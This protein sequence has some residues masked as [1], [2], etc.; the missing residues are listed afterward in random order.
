MKFKEINEAYAVLSDPDKKSRY[1]QFGHAGVDPNGMG[2]AGFG[3]FGGFGGFDFGDIFS[4]FFGGGG[5]SGSRNGPVRGESIEQRIAISFE[6][7]AFGCK[8]TVKYN[9][10][11]KCP[12]CSGSGAAKGTRA[13]TC[14]DCHGSGQVRVSQRTAFGVFQTTKACDNCRGTGKII[15]NPCSNCRGTGYVKLT[16]ELEVTVPAGIDD[17]QRIALRSQ[18]N[19]GRN[20]G[21]AGDLFITVIVRPHT[22]FERDRYDIHCEIPITYAEAVLGAEIAVPTLEGDISYN[23][24]EGT[25][26]GSV[27]TVKGK[28]IQ[29]VNSKSKGDLYFRVIIETPK[30]LNSQQKEKLMEFAQSL[31]ENNHSKKQ[32]FINKIFGKDRK[33]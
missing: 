18:G 14:P 11:E 30:S 25:Q 28:G 12:E 4:S 20:G 29:N 22:I 2:G 24:P 3:D 7:A 26:T 27:F 9:R 33:K 32:K 17:G 21:S 13:E 19:E 8:K 5:S 6:E 15:K 31:G 10:I 23:I 16:K 1:D